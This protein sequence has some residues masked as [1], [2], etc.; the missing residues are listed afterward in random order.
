LRRSAETPL[1]RSTF[2]FRKLLLATTLDLLLIFALCPLSF[3]VFAAAP[4]FDHL[5]P[6][7][8]QIG[9]TN[10]VMAVGKF[11]PWPAKV[12]IDVPGIGFKPETN[13]GKFIVEVAT[14]VPAG[15]HL[16]RL[17]NDQG[18]S[19]PRFLIV[20]HEPQLAE[21]E[22]ND[23]YK[24]PQ[25]VERFPATIN[26]RLEKSGDVDSF[27][28]ALE[29]GQTLIASVQAF[30]LA[31]PVDAVMRLLD[32]GGVQV[33]W[34]H[35]ERTLDPFLVWT[36][37][38]SGTY[39]LQLFGFVYPAQSEVRF[40]GNDK[41][42][43]R[44]HLSRGPY[45]HHT[46]PLGVQRGTN[47]TLQ[48][49]GWNLEKGRHQVQFDG[50]ALS[51]EVSQLLFSVPGLDNVIMLPVGEGPELMEQEPNDIAAEA[52]QLDVS[53]AVTGCIDKIGD[54]DRFRFAAKKDQKF[55]LEVQSSALGFPLD[56]QLRIEDQ[57]GKELARNDDSGGDD[58][59]LEWTAAEDGTFVAAIGNVLHRGGPEYLYR[60]SIRPAVPTVKVNVSETAFTITAGKTNA[61]KVT[62]QCRHGFQSKLRLSVRNLPGHVEAEPLDVPEKGGDVTLQMIASGEAKGFSGPIQII[63]TDMKSQTEHPAV[64]DLTS[65]TVDNGVPGGFNKLVIES[66]DQLWLTVLPEATATEA[67]K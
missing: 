30:S 20:T 46:L 16:V 48:L 52:N 57:K 53:V 37:K 59:K 13:S 29:T 28:I 65:S 60:F 17:F 23:D 50:T 47:T 43:Y 5:F 11:D 56:A 33:A 64:A 66:T 40:T 67:Q 55:L 49:A 54:Q 19:R 42:V 10:S 36:A 58:P 8:I 44:L 62:V 41:C 12:W 38:S 25:A 4:T 63:A 1:R 3:P 14:N 26:G 45:L 6:V 34:N 24:K 27:A 9:T 15:P 31:S 2:A 35:D 18:A 61:I 7:A 21:E 51:A 39:R 22:P 32:A